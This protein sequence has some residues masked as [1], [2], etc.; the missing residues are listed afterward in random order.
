[1]ENNY[2]EKLKQQLYDGIQIKATLVGKSQMTSG[3]EYKIMLEHNGTFAISPYHTNAKD[4]ID[5][6]DIVECLLLDSEAYENTND[7]T[8]FADTFG[9]AD[10]NK[11]KKAYQEC[12]K[13]SERLRKLFDDNEIA[14]L[15]E[16]I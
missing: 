10:Y 5:K 13:Q 8:D 4:I 12:K 16:S 6:Q 9:Y 3:N 14:I 7:V 1:M 2:Q 15:Q 11:A